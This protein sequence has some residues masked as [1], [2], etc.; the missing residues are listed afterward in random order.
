MKKK[1]LF[2]VNVDWF[3]ISHRLPIAVKAIEEGWE[4]TVIGKDTGRVNEITSNGISFI[5]VPFSRSGLNPFQEIV[6]IYRL[7][8]NYKKIKPDIVH[9]V[10]LKPVIYG[11]LISR[12]L[13]VK[14]TVNAVSGLGYTFTE[15]RK[16]FVQ[17]IFLI[18]MKI[19]FKQNNLAIIFQ[20][21]DDYKELKELEVIN[22]F[23][24]INFIKGSGVDL[25]KFKEYDFLETGKIKILFPSRMLW[26]KGVEE[27]RKSSE[28]LKEKYKDKIVFILAG[29][30]DVENKA[31]VTAKYLKD[32]EEEDYV[33]WIGYQKDM[34]K[35]YQNSDIVILPSYREGMPKSLIEACA[36]GRP[37]ITTQAIGCREC[38]D[39]GI[40]G[41]KVKIKSSIELANAIE[42]LVLSE[43][44]RIRMGKNSRLKAEKEFSLNNVIKKHLEIYKNLL[45]E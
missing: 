16:G 25:I 22:K 13:K 19:A 4:V 3:F 26:D 24:K 27:L 20:N 34:I 23:N 32:W 8:K 5:N 41:Y 28:I 7:L 6:S 1:L 2:V 14:G 17:K 37:I 18:L 10:T 29:L 42:K 43:E 45:D 11:S 21:N 15:K 12:F 9:H 31:G 39:E 33:E 36:I 38:V 35:V 44:D 30:A 40:N